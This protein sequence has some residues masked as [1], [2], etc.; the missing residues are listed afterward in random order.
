MGKSIGIDK[1]KDEGVGEQLG[2][3]AGPSQVGEGGKLH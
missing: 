1:L 3:I 2:V